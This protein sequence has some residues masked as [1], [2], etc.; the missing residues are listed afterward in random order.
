MSPE[1]LQLVVFGAL[2]GLALWLLAG[3]WPEAAGP[4]LRLA[5]VSFVLAFALVLHFAWT[6][7]DRMRLL[8]HF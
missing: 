5:L 2:E 6:G 3:H 4:A 8:G 7:A 1:R